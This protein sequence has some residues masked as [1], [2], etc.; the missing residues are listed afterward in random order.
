MLLPKKSIV[1]E[2]PLKRN[3]LLAIPNSLKVV[4]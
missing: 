4:F 1:C 3:E 2:K